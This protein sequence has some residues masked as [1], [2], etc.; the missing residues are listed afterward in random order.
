[1]DRTH[2]LIRQFVHE[3][4]DAVLIADREG[5]IRYWN[6]GAERIFGYAAG[7]AVGRSLDN[8]GWK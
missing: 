8:A 1:M 5:I 4:P 2:H 3:S 7:E 6:T